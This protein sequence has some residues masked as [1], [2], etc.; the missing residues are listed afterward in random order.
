MG[1]STV[2]SILETLMD[3]DTKAAKAYLEVLETL[4]CF[5]GEGLLKSA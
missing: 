4:K 3:C 5:E 2:P 1:D